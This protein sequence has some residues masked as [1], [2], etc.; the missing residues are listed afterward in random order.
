M[1]RLSRSVAHFAGLLEQL[2]KAGYTLVV[3]DL[4]VD[5]SSVTGEAMAGVVSVFAQMERRRIGE[6][7]KEALRAARERGQA[8]GRPRVLDDEIASASSPSVRGND[9]PGI[10][11]ARVRRCRNRRMVAPAG[12]RRR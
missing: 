2:R 12:T 10:G 4:G 5:T 11:C 1:D 8:L 7:T 3:L 9:I 6:R